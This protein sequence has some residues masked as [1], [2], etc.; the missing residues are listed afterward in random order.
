VVKCIFV[1]SPG[2]TKDQFGNFLENQSTNNKN[3]DVIRQNLKKFMYVHSSNGY[4]QALQEILSKP[5]I[6]CKIKDLKASDDIL[7]MEKLNEM[8]AKD[9]E[10]VIFGMKAINIAFEKDAI[11]TLIISDD[12]LRKISGQMRKEV[13]LKMRK[14]KENGRMVVKMSSMHYTGEKI[15]S[16]GGIVGILKYVLE[17]LNECEEEINSTD[18]LPENYLHGNDK[19]NNENDNDFDNM[20][21]DND[22]AEEEKDEVEDLENNDYENLGA[23]KRKESG[24]SYD[25]S[26]KNNKRKPSKGE[27]KERDQS[28]KIA[29]RR[30]SSIEEDI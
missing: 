10:R 23:L 28:R 14:L 24:G 9:M 8:L 25:S 30:K 1:A 3:Y 29:Q 20:F 5:D 4:K 17:E 19:D 2:F 6:M 15:N 26:N 11:D 18:N 16:F 21:D 13:T 27:K 22:L 12:F 7:V